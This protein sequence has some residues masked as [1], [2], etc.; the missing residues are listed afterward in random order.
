MKIGGLTWYSTLMRGIVSDENREPSDL[1]VMVSRENW[2]ELRIAVVGLTSSAASICEL[3][4][5]AA[6][7]K[8][9][10]RPSV[11]LAVPLNTR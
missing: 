5:G 9:G 11:T 2:S 10:T 1:R 3:F 6:S 8:I 4:P 7:R